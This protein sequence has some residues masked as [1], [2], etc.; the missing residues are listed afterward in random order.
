LGPVKVNCIFLGYH[1]S[2]V[3]NKLRRLDD[4]TS[5]VVLYRNMCFNESGKYT[6]TFIGSSVGTG[7]MQVLHGFK[8]EVK[9]LGDHTFDVEPQENIDQGAGLQEVQTQYLMDYQLARD[10]EQHLECELFSCLCKAEIWATKG[11]LA[12]AKGNIL[13]MEIVRDHSG[14]TLRVSQSRDCDVEKNG[15]WSCI[16]AVGSQ[17]YQMVCTRLDIASADVGYG[18]MILGCA[19]SLKSNLQHMKA[20]ST[21]EAGYMT[22]TDAWKKKIW[23]KGLLTESRYELRL[24]AGIATGAL[25]KGGFRYEGGTWTQVTTLLGVVECCHRVIVGNYYLP[26]ISIKGG[27]GE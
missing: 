13:S 7:L 12:K 3:G 25:I 6:K 19:R 11:L 23:L 24:V 9:P 2:I 22:F 27:E 14:N 1:K 26:F 21:T 5:K 17:E 8:F 16:Y 20:R 15:K 18:L 10:K 4:I